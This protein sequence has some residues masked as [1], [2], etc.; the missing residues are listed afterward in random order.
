M[1]NKNADEGAVREKKLNFRGTWREISR[2]QKG[3]MAMMIALAVM[4]AILL[5]ISLVTL[6]PQSTVVIMGY[7]DGYEAL[8]YSGGYRWDSWLNMLA[9]PVLAIAFGVVHNFIALRIYRKYGREMAMMFIILTMCLIVGAV[10]MIFR[11]F[12][13]WQI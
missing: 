8:E 5:I 1:S 3:L 11:L 2:K 12:G 10:M 9:F 4:G 13:E 7:S 6:R